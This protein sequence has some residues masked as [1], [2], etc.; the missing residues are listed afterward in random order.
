MN[1]MMPIIDET[2]QNKKVKS[3]DLSQVIRNVTGVEREQDKKSVLS[4][5]LQPKGIDD[6]QRDV[7]K[8]LEIARKIA[9]GAHVSP[10]EKK[11]LMQTDPRL[12]QMAEMARKEGERI[13]QSLSQAKTKEEQQTVVQQAYQM[14]L[15]VSKKNPQFGMLLGEAVKAAVQENQKKSPKET[16]VGEQTKNKNDSLGT[17]SI[18]ENRQ[19]GKKNVLEMEEQQNLL[20]QFFPEEWMSMLDCRR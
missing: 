2:K 8:A 4:Q 12:A 3:V 10:E 5:L 16:F 15:Q 20:D 6:S 11:F 13:K 19:A 14:V 9:R 17:E 7:K 1:I 18:F